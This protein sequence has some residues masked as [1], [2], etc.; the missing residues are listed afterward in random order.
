MKIDGKVFWHATRLSLLSLAVAAVHQPIA[1]RGVKTVHACASC[2]NDYDCNP[3]DDTSKPA[4]CLVLN[5]RC[6]NS[7]RN[8][9]SG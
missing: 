7:N 4:A 2:K 9:K 3:P 8:C 5:D 6:Y 1:A